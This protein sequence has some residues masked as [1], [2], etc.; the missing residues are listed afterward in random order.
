MRTSSQDA[1]LSHSP[2][3]I[4]SAFKRLGG[5]RGAREGDPNSCHPLAKE[6]AL[7]SYFPREVRGV[8]SSSVCASGGGERGKEMSPLSPGEDEEEGEEARKEEGA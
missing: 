2:L 1:W 6:G 5:K 8:E 7:S 4:P 3:F